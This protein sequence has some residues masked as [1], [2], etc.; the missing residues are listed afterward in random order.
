MKSVLEIVL[1]RIWGLLPLKMIYFF[2]QPLNSC[3]Q[4]LWSNWILG[5]A[6]E[7]V[8]Y[9]RNKRDIFQKICWCNLVF[10]Y[11]GDEFF[12]VLNLSS[13]FVRV[14]LW[15]AAWQ[16]AVKNT[17]DPFSQ[18]LQSDGPNMPRINILVY[19]LLCCQDS[20]FRGVY[21]FTKHI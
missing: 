13:V 17:L 7:S 15:G 9:V 20:L 19:H 3:L 18:H 5:H 4:K 8:P 21:L 11:N 6:F 10:I 2:L 1:L 16:S 12:P 14:V